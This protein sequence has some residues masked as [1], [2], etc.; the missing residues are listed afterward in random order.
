MGELSQVIGKKLENFGSTL[1]EN[2]DC[3]KCRI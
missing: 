2:L 3:S 1:F